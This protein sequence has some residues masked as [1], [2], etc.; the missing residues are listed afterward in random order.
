MFVRLESVRPEQNRFRRYV[1]LVERTLWGTWGVICE[2]GRI[3]E[4]RPRGV[5][6]RECLDRDNALALAAQVIE[7]RLRRGYRVI[8]V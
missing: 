6:L 8:G 5:T 1:V 7:R 4:Q 2:W 3:G